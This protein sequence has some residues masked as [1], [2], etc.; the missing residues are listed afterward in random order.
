M[1][2]PEGTDLVVSPILTFFLGL[3]TS[4]MARDL[5]TPDLEDVAPDK[6]S[7][8]LDT[9]GSFGFTFFAIC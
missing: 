4:Y 3:V 7:L 6:A 5:V 2:V 1:P 9:A 8:N